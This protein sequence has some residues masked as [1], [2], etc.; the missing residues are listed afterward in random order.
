MYKTRRA[1]WEEPIAAGEG[2]EHCLMVSNDTVHH[3]GFFWFYFYIFWHVHVMTVHV[4]VYEGIMDLQSPH[5]FNWFVLRSCQLRFFFLI[6]KLLPSLYQISYFLEVLEDRKVIECIS[7]N[8]SFGYCH[9]PRDTF[10]CLKRGFY[11]KKGYRTKS[12]CFYILNKYL[13][14]LNEKPSLDYDASNWM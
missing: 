9:S 3:L 13:Y 8:V 5:E 10:K 4:T 12:D 1:V 2:A 6:W 11:F 14:I 7:V